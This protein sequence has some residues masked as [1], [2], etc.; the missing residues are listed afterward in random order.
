MY[1]TPLTTL[2]VMCKKHTS[3]VLLAQQLDIEDNENT[4]SNNSHVTIYRSLH[5]KLMYTVEIQD[6][7]TQPIG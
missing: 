7:N 2:V 3:S 5:H 6:V 4:H 1:V